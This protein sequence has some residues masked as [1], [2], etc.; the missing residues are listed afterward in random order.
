MPAASPARSKS[1]NKQTKSL[2][3]DSRQVRAN[4]R[5]NDGGTKRAAASFAAMQGVPVLKA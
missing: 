3:C 1:I 4:K 2:R 5:R